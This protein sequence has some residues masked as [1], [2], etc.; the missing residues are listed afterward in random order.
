MNASGL[1]KNKKPRKKAGVVDC[2]GVQWMLPFPGQ[3]QDICPMPEAK[4]VLPWFNAMP[5][6]DRL[7]LKL[8]TQCIMIV[9]HM[10]TREED[11]ELCLTTNVRKS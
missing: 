5:T 9:K 4:V 11:T 7:C 2:L 3:G 8:Q 1:R 6:C 10:C